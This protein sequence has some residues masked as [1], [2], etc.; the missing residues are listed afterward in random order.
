MEGGT[1]SFRIKTPP[2]LA[3]FVE[4]H[5][6]DAQV[7]TERR[8]RFVADDPREIFLGNRALGDYLPEAGLGWVL[9]V[10]TFLRELDWAEFEASYRAGGRP[11]YHPASMVSLV[12]YGI[13]KGVTSLRTLESLARS[14]LGAMWI[15]GGIAPDHSIIGRFLMR[16]TEQLTTAFF[17]QLTQQVLRCTHGKVT[18]LAGD[19]TVVQA[20]ASRYRKLSEEAAQAAAERARER[21]TNEPE[22]AELARK[23]QV[24]QT[25][26]QTVTTRA[27][28]RRKA[29]KDA[30]R[31]TVSPTEPDAVVQQLKDKSIAPS[32]KPSILVNNQR[33]IVGQAV[34]ASS[35][36]RVV[37]PMIEQAER[38]G[39]GPIKRVMLDAG[40]FSNSTI[41]LSLR[42]DV[43]LLCPE[44]KS[45]TPNLA[46]SGKIFPKSAFTYDEQ[47][48]AY[49][50]PAR[51]TLTVIERVRGNDTKP[52]YRRYATKACATC[53]LRSQCTNSK[54]GRRVN[55]YDGDDA[56]DALRQVMKHPHARALYKKRQAW[57]EPVFADTK[58]R[59]G[60]RRF[61]R[62]GQRGVC[63]EHA[64]HSAAHNLRRLM[65]L[66]PA[67]LR[68]PLW[69]SH[70]AILRLTALLMLCNH[71][72]PQW[73]AGASHAT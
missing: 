44:G 21:A 24:A 32:Y 17:E 59:Q 35:E 11:P 2:Q 71:D 14:D 42:R 51:Q 72:R 13:I 39:N 70:A 53:P 9:Q 1:K 62:R 18:E 47:T 63:L 73:S 43:D 54:R 56:K 41:E 33:I 37:E 20:A 3:L 16:H 55:R 68:G 60:L 58:D 29:G 36:T 15:C 26:V 28:V 8:V 27:D 5:C 25:V 6:A 40:Y 50:C 10:R 48:D 45:R 66:V 23:A 69:R 7:S 38:I 31:V 22:N 12:L 49:Q 34:D 19:G 57:V 67:A 64:L 61:R 4:E 65:A 46:K 52:A 30:S